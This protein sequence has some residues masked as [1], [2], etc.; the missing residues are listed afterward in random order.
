MQI[1]G[2]AHPAQQAATVEFG[3][4][5]DG[6]GGLPARVE[7]EHRVVDVLVRGPVEVAGP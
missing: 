5:G 7:I 2:S 1:E 4:D 6:V 3:R